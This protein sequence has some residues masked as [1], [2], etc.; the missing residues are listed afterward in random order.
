MLADGLQ[1]QQFVHTFLQLTDVLNQNQQLMKLV[2]LINTTIVQIKTQD[3]K[4]ITHVHL[5][6]VV[7]Q[8]A[9]LVDVDVRH[10]HLV[11]THLVELKVINLHLVDVQN[12]TPRLVIKTVM[13]TLAIV[14]L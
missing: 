10:I 8:H 2:V 1:T 3:A 6:V 4:H 11:E 12:T 13:P 7:M 9:D 14:E 5:V